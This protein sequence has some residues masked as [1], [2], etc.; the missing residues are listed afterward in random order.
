MTKRLLVCCLVWLPF[1]I[2]AQQIE[3]AWVYFTDK[4]DVAT[5][6]ANPI[7]ILT[8]KAIDRKNKHGVAIDARDVEVNETYISQIKGAT[9]ITVYAKSKW[10]NAVHVRGTEANINNLET[11]FSFVDHIE[12]ADRSLN[13]TRTGLVKSFK[14]I[15]K[16]SFSN[17]SQ[18]SAGTSDFCDLYT[19]L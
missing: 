18:A 7:T 1:T 12:F 10:F 6:I 8:Q 4:V 16:N 9:G 14:D 3:D 11:T 2:S 5:K 17:E 15:A 19:K 13:T